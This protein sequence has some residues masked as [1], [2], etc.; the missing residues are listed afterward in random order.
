M[1]ANDA[2]GVIRHAGAI[3]IRLLLLLLLFIVYSDLLLFLPNKTKFLPRGCKN[4]AS[5]GIVRPSVTLWQAYWYCIR[6]NKTRWAGQ[7]PT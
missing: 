6:I 2:S 1:L 4:I 7:S 3:Q 5:A